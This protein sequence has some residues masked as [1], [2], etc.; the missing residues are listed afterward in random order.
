[1]TYEEFINNILKTRGRF[2]CGN[3]YHETHHILPRCLGGTDDKENLVDLFAREHYEA[4][5]LLALENPS[6][7][8]LQ[9]AWWCMSVM[10]NKNTME[11]YQITAEE[12]EEARKRFIEIPISEERR[13]KL[14]EAGKRRRH[15]KETRDKMSKKAKERCK[16]PENCSMY[17]KHHS[18]ETK[19]KMKN[20]HA[21][22]SGKNNPNYGK[23]HSEETRRKMSEGQKNRPPISEKTRKRMSEINKGEN[24]PMYGKHPSEETL[25]KMSEAQK[26][27]LV[28]EETRRKISESNKGR[29]VGEKSPCAKSVV[30][31]DLNG[32]IIRVWVC[33]S[34]ASKEL[35][36]SSSDISACCKGK[37]KT[38][39]G[40]KWR[41]KDEHD[42]EMQAL[43]TPTTQQND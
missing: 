20:N 34:Q 28:S 42:Q 39:G 8:G 7:K 15:S 19:Q 16:N 17:G 27:H 3:E 21:D 26:G 29:Y 4:H 31:Y 37:L 33:I 25:K 14:S 5:R 11:R 43:N 36:M 10:T 2:E 6:N 12:Y 32:N 35:N 9:Y 13:Q 1:M 30:Q 18:E 24:N 22:I 41:Y 38:A 23:H 40:F